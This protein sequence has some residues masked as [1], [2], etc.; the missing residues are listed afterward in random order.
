VLD[1]PLDLAAQ[2]TQDRHRRSR[3][4]RWFERGDPYQQHGQL[5]A[6]QRRG[7]IGGEQVRRGTARVPL[8]VG[9]ELRDLA[10]DRLAVLPT[11][12]PAR[13]RE[14]VVHEVPDLRQL[15]QAREGFGVERE[16]RRIEPR[17]SAELVDLTRPA[18]DQRAGAAGVPVEVE[19]VAAMAD[20]HQ[21]DE[22]AVGAKWPCV[23]PAGEELT[24][25]GALDGASGAQTGRP[26]V[27]VAQRKQALTETD[28]D[29]S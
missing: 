5:M 26:G 20:G 25:S 19:C 21:Q 11:G 12:M 15:G 6:Q 14:G 1:V 13:R 29:C 18:P 9:G 3:R 16:Q 7:Q 28:H 17:L 22:V 10:G 2:P 24:E 4:R 23:G 27:R 8:A